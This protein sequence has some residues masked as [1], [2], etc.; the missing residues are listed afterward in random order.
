MASFTNLGLEE[1]INDPRFMIFGG[2]EDNRT[3]N[4]I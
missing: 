4:K 3:Q 1:S 2:F